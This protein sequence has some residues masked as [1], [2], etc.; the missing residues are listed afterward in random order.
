[1]AFQM[2]IILDS[3]VILPQAYL[4]VSKIYLEYKDVDIVNIELSVY[5]D[6]SSF[7]DGKPEVTKFDFSCSGDAFDTYFSDAYLNM[8][9]KNP[10]ASVH[11]WLKL[12]EFFFDAEEL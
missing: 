2:E 9:D 1:M 4:T 11:E 5:K 7:S 8:V 10:K 12:Q 6:Y 3:G